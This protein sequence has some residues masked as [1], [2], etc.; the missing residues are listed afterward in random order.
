M[1][2]RAGQISVLVVFSL[3][4]LFILFTFVVN[5]GML[6]N[7]KIALQNAADLA[8]YAGA[9]TQ[10]RQMTTISH[11][12]YQMRQAYKKFIARQYVGGNYSLKCFP[13]PNAGGNSGSGCNPFS[14]Q[15]AFDFKNANSNFAGAP[16]VC[17]N[18]SQ[19]S[20][21]CQ[22]AQ[23]VR[24]VTP[25]TGCFPIDPI[26]GIVTQAATQIQQIQKDVCG[27]GTYL[28]VEVALNWL[29]ATEEDGK[30]NTNADVSGMIKGYGLVVENLLNYNRIE[31][32]RS[33][34]NEQAK[35]VNANTLNNLETVPDV[36]KTE[37]TVLAFKTLQGNL[38]SKVF[39]QI[40][41]KE[42]MPPA[43][44]FINKIE[45]QITVPATLFNVNGTTCDLTMYL[46]N[47]RPIV[48]VYVQENSPQQV[49]Y[50][51]KAQAK[52]RLLFNPFP[53]GS[54]DPEGIT[55]TA[56]A[57]ARPFGSR[58]GPV[59]K[60]EDVTKRRSILINGSS[61]NI[62]VAY[63]R[64]D[65]DY[66]YDSWGVLESF[67]KILAPGQNQQ[68]IDYKTFQLM[69]LAAKFPD[70]YEV[71]K[72]NIPVD[73]ESD[74][75]D[76]GMIRYFSSANRNDVYTAWAPMIS[77]TASVADLKDKIK[78]EI[79]N[80]I[81]FSQAGTTGNAVD[82]L[83]VDVS[84]YLLD[85][86]DGLVG[87]LRQKNN[88][89]VAQI[90]DPFH[91]KVFETSSISRPNVKGKIIDPSQSR[92]LATSFSTIYDKNY[93][94]A[95]RDGYSV[96]LIPMSAVLKISNGFDLRGEKAEASKVQ[97]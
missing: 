53:K 54:P 65:E 79:Q 73:V 23:S 46:I 72:Y 71:G 36:A 85:K 38:N 80:N 68:F 69:E 94:E 8:A 83:K 62:N 92:K 48:G 47:A 57:A 44:L 81:S 97:H 26:C 39:D 13:H 60:D 88:Y 2:K 3:L 22:L 25:P 63:L 43:M 31:T 11:I 18:L 10:A 7:A 86:L 42:L 24:L 87:T 33:F 37:R 93:Y 45:P 17:I 96:K 30:L 91:R 20:N 16:V 61:Q 5:M 35:D 55:L 15:D 89:T 27:A 51:I 28:N 14:D 40:Q 58:I 56:Y 4:P 76:K 29:Y 32:M 70:E 78:E 41:M 77:S 64:L 67:S 66:A 6:V 50:S 52:A 9:A 12:N 82:Q 75:P 1:K 95:G 74:T 21:A 49:F 59:L 90:E 19:S 84:K 34:I